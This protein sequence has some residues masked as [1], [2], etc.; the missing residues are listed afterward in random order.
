MELNEYQKQ[1]MTTCTKTSENFA[2]M[3][4]NLAGEVGELASRARQSNEESTQ[5][6]KYNLNNNL[7]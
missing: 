6:N 7:L 1:A 4:L 3:M 5:T 2:Y